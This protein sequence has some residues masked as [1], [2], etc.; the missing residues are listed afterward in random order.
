MNHKTGCNHLDFLGV[1]SSKKEEAENKMLQGRAASA[2]LVFKR[3]TGYAM[4]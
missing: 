3:K 2:F 1:F 4:E